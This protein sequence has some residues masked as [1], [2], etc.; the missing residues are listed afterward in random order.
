MAINRVKHARRKG[1]P[2]RPD[3]DPSPAQVDVFFRVFAEDLSEYDARTQSGISR[4]QLARLKADLAFLARY[5][6]MRED[7]LDRVEHAAYRRAII[8]G[9]KDLIKMLLVARRQ[10]DYAPKVALQLNVDVTKLTSEELDDLILKH[11]KR[12][13]G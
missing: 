10:Q 3:E 8:N 4:A 13:S 7:L 9:D 5:D 6:D 1:K 2:V 11:N 12:S